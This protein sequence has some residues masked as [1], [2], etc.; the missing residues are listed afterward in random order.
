M[1][2]QIYLRYIKTLRGNICNEEKRGH[3]QIGKGGQVL[4]AHFRW[5]F[6]MLRDRPKR[7]G[8]PGEGVWLEGH[9]ENILLLRK[10]IGR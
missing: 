3:G 2:N 8:H 7:Q 10:W 5:V 6:A 4:F 9:V 1:Y